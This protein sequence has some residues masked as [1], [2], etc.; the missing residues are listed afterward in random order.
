MIQIVLEPHLPH[1]CLH[2]S[3]PH[4]LRSPRS[5]LPRSPGGTQLASPRTERTELKTKTTNQTIKHNNQA[6][7]ATKHQSNLPRSPVERQLASPRT[8]KQE[9]YLKTSNQTIKLNNQVKQATKQNY[10]KK[11]NKQP[12]KQTKQTSKR[13]SLATCWAS[14]QLN[15]GWSIPT[16]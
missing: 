10:E 15:C 12:K 4:R 6:K 9:T 14:E 3:S 2:R 1:R 11:L 5:N 8:G 7:Q 16:L 13:F